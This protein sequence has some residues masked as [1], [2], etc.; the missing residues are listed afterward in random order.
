M[1]ASDEDDEVLAAVFV[2]DVK[3]AQAAEIAEGD[4]AFSVKA[5]AANAV[6]E[7]RMSR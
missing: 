1:G 7:L 5:V 2:A 4:T 3:V 6:I